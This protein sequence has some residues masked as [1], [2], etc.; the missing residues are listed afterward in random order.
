M[1]AYVGPSPTPAPSAYPTYIA[2]SP[3][4]YSQEIINAKLNALGPPSPEE[5]QFATEII[6][7]GQW[8]NLD[9]QDEHY[10]R[11]PTS[12]KNLYSRRLDLVMDELN[13]HDLTSFEI[14]KVYTALKTY[15]STHAGGRRSKSRKRKHRKSKTAKRRARR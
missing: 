13:I 12:S 9:R 11:M 3:K 14:Q 15:Y 6:Q 5:K 7:A 1:A 4:P 8:L 2:P 10:A